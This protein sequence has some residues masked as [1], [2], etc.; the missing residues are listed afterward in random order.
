MSVLELFGAARD[1]GRLQ[2][3][4][5]TL[6][7]HGFGDLVGRLKLAGPLERAGRALRLAR[8]GDFDP[9][10]PPV[11]VRRAL[12]ELGTTF[13]KLGQV[14]ATRPDLLP[15]E[16]TEEL[17]KLQEQVAPVPFEELNSVLDE[18]WGEDWRTRFASFD[19]TPLAAGSVGQVHRATLISGE[20]VVVKV[21]RPKI[22][23]AVRSDLRMM[24]KLAELAT[25]ELP[26]LRRYRPTSMVRHLGRVLRDELD[27]VQEARNT[28]RLA[29]T[30]QGQEGV[31]LP[32]VFESFTSERLLVL[33]YM[34]GVSAARWIATSEPTDLDRKLLAERGCGALLQMIFEHGC[35]HADPHPGNVLFLDPPTVRLAD[36]AESPCM[37]DEL[38]LVDCGMVGHLSQARQREFTDLLLYTQARDEPRVAG[39]LL[40]WSD[41]SDPPD[42]DL[43][44]TDVRAFLDRYHGASLG[45][46]EASQMLGDVLDI[47]RD[48]GL[49]LPPDLLTLIRVFMLTESMGRALDSEFDLTAALEPFVRAKAASRLNPIH[50]AALF[51]REMAELTAELPKDLRLL[52][53]RAK[54][55]RLHL[56]LDMRRLD[57][58]ADQLESSLNRLVVGLVTA[59]LIVG[60]AIAM[61]VQGGPTLFGLPALGFLGFASSLMLGFGL[62]ISLWRSGR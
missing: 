4:A 51:S 8:E 62:L 37:R 12:E 29:E 7:R 27:F 23:E 11:R 44:A 22:R 40:S 9:V 17:G 25:S 41:D 26:E 20:Q 28:V 38:A 36:G 57:H 18:D 14:L 46:V 60:T 58:V 53:D 42:E 45:E 31:H 43:L 15:P 32:R 48:N 19:E 35:Y 5:G 61:T 16:W 2:D 34:A 3:I 6:V 55:G 50:R 59:A 10:D 33:E 39:L 54:S 24:E 52:I 56:G 21:R 47:V 1:L 30:M 13:V 49:V